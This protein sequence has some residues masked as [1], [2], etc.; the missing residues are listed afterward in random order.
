[1]ARFNPV[2]TNK[3]PR[4]EKIKNMIWGVVN[5][6]IF[7]ITP[8]ILSINRKLRVLML[9]AFGAKV[10]MHASIHPSAKI[11]YPWRLTMGDR[12]SLGEKAWA[13]CLNSIAIGENTCIG[14]DV[15]LLTGSH[16]ISSPN[17]NLVTKPITIGDGVWIATGS[18]VLPGV[19]LGDLTVVGAGSVVV[20]NT[21]DNDVIGGNPAKFIK[22][23]V[24]KDE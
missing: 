4:S 20:K 23:R 2:Q 6:T 16:D 22:K 13:Y 9:R 8:P 11:D 7:R 17:F 14:K 24:I 18:T 3:M 19:H 5:S 21:D 12:S 1:M 15:Y 10:S